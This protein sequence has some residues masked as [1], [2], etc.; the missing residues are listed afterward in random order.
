MRQ[1]LDTL[2]KLSAALASVALIAI[3]A[4]VFSQVALN[5]IDSFSTNVFGRQMT[6][7][8]PSYSLFSG[9]ALGWA[10]FLSLG[11]G[12]RKAVHIR[13]TLLE[14]RLNLGVRRFTLTL[15]AVIGTVASGFMAWHFSHLAYESWLWGDKASGLVKLP[16]YIPQLGMTVG[17]IV[18]FISC[19]DTLIEMLRYGQS[20]AL[21]LDSTVED[22]IQ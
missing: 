7:L 8:I 13:V 22:A 1:A 3:C 11:Y 14:G 10:T 9:Y 21:K 4:I 20:A 17:L 5:M 12:F 15:V 2:Y 18:F 6:V 16:L 19:L